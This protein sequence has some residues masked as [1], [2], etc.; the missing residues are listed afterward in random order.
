M[1]MR[2]AASCGQPLHVR[3]LPRGART[4][5]AAAVLLFIAVSRRRSRRRRAGAGAD[6]TLD[7]A[8]VVGEDPVGL[9]ER[10]GAPHR[11]VGGP[12]PA[13]GAQGREKI[14]RLARGQ[15]TRWPG[16]CRA[17]SHTTAPCAPR[18]GP[19]DTDLPG[20][21]CQALDFLA[22]LRPGRG[23]RAAYEA[24]RRAVPFMETDRVLADD[25]R[26]VEGLI[27]AGT[28]RAAAR[29]AAGRLR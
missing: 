19:I 4:S 6:Q 15:D 7:V 21:P 16:P 22:P 18:S 24:V 20:S 2:R 12:R 9:H 23:A 13:A 27:R 25:I 10:D 28:L 11:L 26:D 1:S 3:S 29:A 17:W 8:D 5:R 14:E